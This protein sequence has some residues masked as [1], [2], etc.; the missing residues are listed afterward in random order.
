[1]KKFLIVFFT[2]ILLLIP[3]LW[4]GGRWILSSSIA[5]YDGEIKLTGVSN[6]IEITFDAKGIP[7]IWAKNNKDLYFALGWL[8]ASERLFQ[9]ELVRRFTAGELSEIFGVV[10]YPIDVQQRRLGFVRKAQNDFNSLEPQTLLFLQSYCSG[11]NSWIDYTNILPPEFFLLKLTPRQWKPLDCLSIGL[12]QTWFAHS[13][14]NKDIEYDE[15]IGDFGDEIKKLLIEVKD[16]SPTVIQKNFTGSFLDEYLFPMTMTYASNSFIVSPNKSLSGKAIHACDPHLIINQIPGFWYVVGLHSDEGI[17]DIGVTV[18]GLPFV[19]MGHT[20]KISYGFTVASVNLVDYYIEKRNP[21][22]S[23]QVLTPTGYQPMEIIEEEFKVKDEDEPKV[24]TFY[25]TKNG[26]VVESDSGKVVSLK[27]AG[28]DFNAADILNSAFKLPFVDNF[29]DFKNTV[30]KFGALDVNWTYSDINGNIGYQLGSPIPKRNHSEYFTF[31]AGENPQYQWDGYHIL[32]ET[33][34]VINPQKGWIASCNNQ[35]VSEDWPYDI[36]GFYDPY[37]IIRATELLGQDR[38]FSETEL[39]KIQ[40]DWVSVSALRWKNLM[41]AGAEKLNMPTL[42]SAIDDWNGVMFKHGKIPAIFAY[43][44]EFLA[45][46][47]FHDALGTD[48]RLGQ[49][50]QEEVLTN[51]V[52][53]II[54]NLDTPG[55]VETPIDISAI[56]LDSALHKANNRMYAE[57]A[58]LKL[59]HPLSQVKL[60]DYWLNLNRGPFEMG[61]DFSTLN[62]NIMLYEPNTN[63]FNTIVAPSMRFVLDWAKIDSF[64]IILNLGQSGNPFNPH[65]DDFLD[66]WKNGKTWM[67]PFSKEKVYESKEHLLKILPSD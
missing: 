12:Y 38:K 56:A 36:P 35:I 54:D 55:Y 7:Q 1:M 18:P 43:W 67:V 4:F 13:L 61:G 29:E 31:L 2:G 62:A 48:W 28:F 23:L 39:A 8:H 50:I 10:V 24:Q 52:E 44:W 25:S 53:N 40:L 21:Q 3:A 34:S 37:R 6:E 33:P 47:L 64:S 19:A 46:P 15:L 41:K 42:A 27:W 57:V 30:T 63:E 59:S 9:M 60:L 16:W 51:N 20:D 66:L 65:Y 49:V 58:K 45:Y 14:M 17:N 22:D 11:V 26:P 5:D 32:S